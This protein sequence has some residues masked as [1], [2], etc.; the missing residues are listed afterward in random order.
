MILID[1]SF[2][3]AIINNKD[4][5]NERAIT[6]YSNI[7]KEKKIMPLLMMSESITSINSR[8]G[9]KNT[10][11]LYKTLEKEFNIYYP[12]KNDITKSMEILSKYNNLSLADSLAIY[13][14]KKE[15]ITDIYSFD[16][17]FDKVDG[18]IR[19]Y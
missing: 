15:N 9:V 1:S 11:E 19:K 3:I 10:I 16:S 13:I 2:I 4:Q 6:L 17:D 8:L 18:I 12:T 5:W 7:I 14:M